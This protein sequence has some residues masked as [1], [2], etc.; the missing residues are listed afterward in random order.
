[1]A[2]P[3][4]QMCRCKSICPGDCQCQAQQQGVRDRCCWFPC[5][6]RPPLPRSRCPPTPTIGKVQYRGSCFWC[7]E[8]LHTIRLNNNLIVN[9]FWFFRDSIESPFR[10]PHLSEKVSQS[11]QLTRKG[12]KSTNIR[13]FATQKLCRW[14]DRSISTTVKFYQLNSMI[15]DDQ[16]AY[17]QK[18]CKKYVNNSVRVIVERWLKARESISIHHCFAKKYNDSLYAGNTRM[19]RASRRMTI[20]TAL[21]L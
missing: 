5:W 19:W 7:R 11:R 1:M 18:N 12:G 8:S 3:S 9:E 13:F 14:R 15:F 4:C 2:F 6:G 17:L 21:S 16:V 10:K 20:I